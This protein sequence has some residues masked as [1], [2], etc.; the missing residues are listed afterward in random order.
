ML[1][2]IFFGSILSILWFLVER[3]FF[4]EKS[5]KMSG[6]TGIVD[7]TELSHV[8]I[9]DEPREKELIEM[10]VFRQSGN[11]ERTSRFTTIQEAIYEVEKLFGRIKEPSVR[12]WANEKSVLD[13]RRPYGSLNGRN[14]GNKIWGCSLQLAEAN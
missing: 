10:H 8:V 7:L 1:Y 13:V 6:L 11:W 14:A 12:I 2:A 5:K 4:S 3:L 9:F